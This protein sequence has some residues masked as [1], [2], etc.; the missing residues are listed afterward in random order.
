MKIETK[1]IYKCEH[2]NKL[3]QIKSYCATHETQCSKNPDNFRPCFGC[4]HLEKKETTITYETPI[5]ENEYKVELLH[6][7]KKELFLYPPKVEHK[8]N[9]YD[10]DHE[11]KPMPR[12]CE[13][14]DDGWNSL[15]IKA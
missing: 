9:A 10:F 1:E 14:E 2:C 12:E 7:K 15:N 3:Y 11:N 4:V 13:D 5:G 6:C 8:G